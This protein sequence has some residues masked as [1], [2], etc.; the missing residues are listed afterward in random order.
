MKQKK[1]VKVKYFRLLLRQLRAC[2]GM[3]RP[4]LIRG[5]DKPSATILLPRLGTAFFG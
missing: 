3:H 5:L 1:E 4:F 2:Y